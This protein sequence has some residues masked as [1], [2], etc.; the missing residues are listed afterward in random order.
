MSDRMSEQDHL[1]LEML[2]RNK[3]RVLR[4]C[5]LYSKGAEEQKDLFQ[6]VTL[7][8]W[9]S[10]PSFRGEAK[11]T[12]WVY[13]ICLNTCLKKLQKGKKEEAERVHFQQ[14]SWIDTLPEKEDQRLTYLRQCIRSLREADQS[15]LGLY[16]EDLPYADIAE[17]TGL[18]GNHVAVKMK[19][20]REKLFNCISE[21]V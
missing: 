6:E 13:R 8:L 9:R 4:I 19:R 18:S 11:Q 15:V 14:L 20:I 3:D 1:F 17:I 5:S 16:L 21:K 2:R 10:F 7:Q 12:T